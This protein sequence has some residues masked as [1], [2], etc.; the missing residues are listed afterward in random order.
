VDPTGLND[1]LQN[2]GQEYSVYTYEMLNKGIDRD[3]LL[4]INDEQLLFE[5]GITNKIHRLKIQQGVKVERGDI[6][7]SEESLDK[8]LDVFVSYRRSNGSQLASLLKV[9]RSLKF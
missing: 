9:G 7:Y 4:S 1:F 3:T 2:L 6:S 5:C 8:S